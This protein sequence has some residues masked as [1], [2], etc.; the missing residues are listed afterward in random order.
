MSALD[1]V[2]Y[3]PEKHDEGECKLIGPENILIPEGEYQASYL[4]FETCGMFGK[5]IKG[6]KSR[7][8]N[9]KLYVWFWIDPYGEKLPT[10]RKVELY[11]PYNCS[12]VL[13]PIGKGGEF[14]MSRK[15]KYAKEFDR[16][17]GIARRD[18]ISPNA[19]KNKIWKVRVG[20]VI[21]SEKQNVHSEDECYSVIREIIK[22]DG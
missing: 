2:A 22:V 4:H 3:F 7:L 13:H 20:T 9:G 16:L 12:A 10:D 21:T 1:N 17:I 14:D 19:F 8:K 6:D 5:K 18:R 11:M 15:K